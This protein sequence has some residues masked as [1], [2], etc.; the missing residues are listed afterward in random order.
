MTSSRRRSVLFRRADSSRSSLGDAPCSIVELV[1][2][3]STVDKQV[4]NKARD[5]KQTS[6]SGP[7]AVTTMIILPLPLAVIAVVVC[8]RVNVFHDY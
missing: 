6:S 5:E 3:D 8:K 2:A 1:L 4:A 7:R